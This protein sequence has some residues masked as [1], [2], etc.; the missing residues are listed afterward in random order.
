MQVKLTWLLGT[1]GH[2]QKHQK[3]EL[4]ENY[5]PAFFADPY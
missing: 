4:I 2:T 1:E 3:N 5:T